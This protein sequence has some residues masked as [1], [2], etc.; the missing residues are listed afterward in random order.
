MTDHPRWPVVVGS[1]TGAGLAGFGVHTLLA[2][3]SDT[4]PVVVVRWVI[5]LALVHDLVLAPVVLLVATAVHR[6]APR[7]VRAVLAGVLVV[8][9]VLVLEAW[10]AL[11]GYGRIRDNP[12]VLPRNYAVG[13][14]VAVAVVWLAGLALV[15]ARARWRRFD[16]NG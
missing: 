5:G 1:L 10:P 3:A 13:L 7:P 6:W 16:G 4:R 15:G 12:T 11:R 14:G 8:T 9:G 2:H